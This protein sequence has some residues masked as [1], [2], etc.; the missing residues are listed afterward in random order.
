[1]IVG[2][3]AEYAVGRNV[4]GEIPREQLSQFIVLRDR[5]TCGDVD[6][7]EHAVGVERLVI[8]QRHRHVG[9]RQPPLVIEAFWIWNSHGG[10]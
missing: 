6:V 8:K 1:M 10:A 7:Y 3:H 2:M 9:Y 4:N 5:T